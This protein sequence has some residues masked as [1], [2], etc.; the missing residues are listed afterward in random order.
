M[1]NTSTLFH[2]SL[3]AALAVLIGAL[4]CLTMA[5]PAGAPVA[6]GTA[7]RS[8]LPSDSIHPLPVALTDQ[9]GNTFRLDTLR[10]QPMLISMFFT[11]CQFVCPMLTDALRD[12]ANKLQP[13]DCER[14]KV[15]MVTFD[16]ARDS[17]AVLKRTAIAHSLTD[18]QW[19][20]ARTDE[21]STR[22]LA[23]VLNIQ[24]KP[25]AD[26]DFNHTTALILIDSEGR[27]VGRS[28][29]LGGADP[30][31]VKLVQAAVQR[32]PR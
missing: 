10:G 29:Q 16:P 13:A 9:N 18:A 30:A 19:T 6:T 26:G 4:S 32:A 14:L 28:S 11:S 3:R 22:K 1:N 2:G 23:A 5:A 8:A 21:A 12:T 24:Y 20:L 27:M 25:L 15:V 7:M 31:F 17:V